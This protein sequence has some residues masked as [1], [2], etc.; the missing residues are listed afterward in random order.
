M[1]KLE[2]LEALQ[3]VWNKYGKIEFNNFTSYEIKEVN[4]LIYDIECLLREK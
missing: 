1:T 4:D 3:D 2:K